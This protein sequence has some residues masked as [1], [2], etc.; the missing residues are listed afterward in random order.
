MCTNGV[1]GLQSDSLNFQPQMLNFDPTV[2]SE[3]QLL[4]LLLGDEHVGPVP[5]LIVRP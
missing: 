1:T 4:L 5:F 2:M 3:F